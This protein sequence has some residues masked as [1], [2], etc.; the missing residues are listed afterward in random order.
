MRGSAAKR[1]RLVEILGPAG[2]G[3]GVLISRFSFRWADL[4]E[5]LDVRPV[6]AYDCGAIR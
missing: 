4:F 6:R 3:V 1:I 5:A 2:S